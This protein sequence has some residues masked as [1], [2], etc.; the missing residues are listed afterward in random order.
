MI[1]PP[2]PQTPARE[3]P[4]AH[5]PGCPPRFCSGPHPRRAATRACASRHSVGDVSVHAA[6]DGVSHRTRNALLLLG[7]LDRRHLLERSLQDGALCAAHGFVVQSASMFLRSAPA[8]SRARSVSSRAS[9]STMTLRC[10]FEAGG[11]GELF[12]SL[13]S[14]GAWSA[15]CET[16]MFTASRAARLGRKAV[17][18]HP[19]AAGL[20]WTQHGFFG[21]RGRGR[22]HTSRGRSDLVAVCNAQ[23]EPLRRECSVGV[24]RRSQRPE[25]QRRGGAQTPVAVESGQH[26]ARQ[27]RPRLAAEHGEACGSGG[28]FFAPRPRNG[29]AQCLQLH[30]CK[31]GRGGRLR[32]R[33]RR[34]LHNAVAGCRLRRPICHNG[35][36]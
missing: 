2:P 23:K 28:V 27:H 35:I 33:G 15:P 30:L 9:W 26:A 20:A 17:V 10:A 21:G 22:D 4:R 1:A 19:H 31:D 32:C 16:E 13:M 14:R 29:L 7:G 24:G 5:E 3:T 25:R 11:L 34:R 18:L 8:A 36:S 12:F 6:G